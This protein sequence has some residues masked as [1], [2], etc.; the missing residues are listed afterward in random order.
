M[1]G[2]ENH[3]DQPA[4]SF[5]RPRCW[6]GRAEPEG[7]HKGR[8]GGRTTLI[9]LPLRAESGEPEGITRVAAGEGMPSGG[10]AFTDGSAAEA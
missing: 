7:N 5:A 8:V 3:A 4:A 9:N 1:G 6:R 10:G 2:W